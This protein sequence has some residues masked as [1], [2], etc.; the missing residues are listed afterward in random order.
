MIRIL[1]K[2]L[3]MIIIIPLVAMFAAALISL[4]MAPVYR[5]STIVMVSAA[6]ASGVMS[7]YNSLNLNRQLVKTY[8]ELAV[9]QDVLQEVAN[10]LNGISPDALRDQITVSPVKD[11]ELL[12]IS[13]KDKSPE[14]AAFIASETVNVLRK[15]INQLYGSDNIRIVSNAEIP[16]KQEQPN[17][18]V[19]TASAG[20]AGLI[21]AIII[22]F[23]RE[24]KSIKALQC[25]GFSPNRDR[26]ER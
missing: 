21:I 15:K 23:W 11:L 13:V 7:D 17:I 1:K 5:S 8:G 9:G 6:G 22:A 12:K 18:V 16:L 26:R 24:E 19:N 25:E 10:K 4:V 3:D 2:W 14:R 20:V